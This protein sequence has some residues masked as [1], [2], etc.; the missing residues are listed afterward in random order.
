V[1]YITFAVISIDFLIFFN[2]FLFSRG[3]SCPSS[4]QASLTQNCLELTISGFPYDCLPVSCGG[5]GFKKIVGRVFAWESS[6]KV[7][8]LSLGSSCPLQTI[9]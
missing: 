6:L 3:L 5:N 7:P 8:L 1:L 9:C 4:V 2:P